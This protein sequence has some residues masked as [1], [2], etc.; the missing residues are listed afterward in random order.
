MTSPTARPPWIW[1]LVV[2]LIGGTLSG[3][4][5]VGGGIVMVP[6]LVWLAGMDQKVASATSLAAIVPSVI[7][8]SI[9]YLLRGEVD[10][11][12]ALALGLGAVPGALIGTWIL[13]RINIG[14][15]R[16]LFI[17]LM[18]GIAAR[19]I[20]I[21]VERGE[22]LDATWWTYAL[23]AVIGVLTGIASGLFGVG[24]GVIMVPVLVVGFGLGDLIAKGTSLVAMIA[25]STVGTVSNMR[26]GTV[27]VRAG[28]LVGVAATAASYGGVLLAFIMPPRLSAV[29][30]AALL[31]LSA[32]Q[33]TIRTLRTKRN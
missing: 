30:F 19:M 21:E 13:R 33:L 15:L 22:S 17:A 26:S 12:A 24:G 6:L 14:L 32:V 5:G 29:L 16:W 7:V 11:L 27:D 18:V 9:G 25:S 23:L 20:F 31:L 8:G 1:L 2:G 4:F 10:L 3:A 28:L